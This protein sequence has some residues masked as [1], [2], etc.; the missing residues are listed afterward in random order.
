[1]SWGEGAEKTFTV[2][3]DAMT[4]TYGPENFVELNFTATDESGTPAVP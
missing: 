1:M 2:G 4:V 3:Y